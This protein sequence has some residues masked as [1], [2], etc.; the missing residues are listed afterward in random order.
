[1]AAEC[2][3]VVEDANLLRTALQV[4]LQ[5][6]GYEVM[7]APTIS[8]AMHAT[9]TRLPDLLIL[10][11]TVLDA[12]PFAGLTDGFSFL[13]LLRR[14]H[15]EA[16]FPVIVYTGDPSPAVQAKAN[17]NNV[18][19][20]IRKGIQTQELISIVRLALDEWANRR[21]CGAAQ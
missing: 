3:L 4:Q 11:L 12:D 2:I 1:M 8:A 17:A 10:D 7:S 18:F 14:S 20:V 16:D 21:P 6:Q 13:S 5:A 15:P 9:Q 19:A